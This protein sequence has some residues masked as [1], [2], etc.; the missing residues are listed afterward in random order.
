[1]TAAKVS[2]PR[3]SARRA[4]ALT[5]SSTVT[6]GK[7]PPQGLP[8]AGLGLIGPVDPWHPPRL[9]TPTTKNRSV[10]SGLPGPIMLS[11]QPTLSGASAYTPATWC[12]AF[13]AWGTSTALERAASSF[14]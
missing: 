5:Q 3:W 10:S 9:L 7:S 12:E 4:W 6:T 8:V 13:S 11:H 1:M 2:I 14:P